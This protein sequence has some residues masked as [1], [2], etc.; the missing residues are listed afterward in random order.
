MMDQDTQLQEKKLR[1][2]GG[3][4]YAKLTEE[5]QK[6]ANLGGPELFIAGVGRLDQDRFSKYYCNKCERDYEGSPTIIYETP[7]EELGEGVTLTEKGEYKCRTCDN[8]L[9]QYRKFDTPATP[10]V[11]PPSQKHRNAQSISNKNEVSSVKLLQQSVDTNIIN[12]NNV[13][14]SDIITTGSASPSSPN[15][16]SMLS[17]IVGFVPIQSLV[18]M[19]A[20]DSEAILIGRVK[21][22]GLSRS[23]E[24]TIQ[25]SVKIE[26]EGNSDIVNSNTEY[27]VLWDNIS[28][29]GDIML[30]SDSV[31]KPGTRDYAPSSTKGST[32]C[33]SCGYENQANAAFCEECGKKLT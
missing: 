18:G 17:S 7:N 5:E 13:S 21:E 24:G 11:Q 12:N 30:L 27:E 23:A 32:K 22:I 4:A 6:R 3:H 25:I 19:S 15:K 29:I 8:V 16:I 26:R 2:S 10:T 14:Q 31:V 33:L 20:Y 28:K 9:A 1:G